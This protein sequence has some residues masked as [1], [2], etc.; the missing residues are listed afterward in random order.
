[1]DTNH[2]EL[3]GG[4]GF[5]EAEEEEENPVDKVIQQCINHLSRIAISASTFITS[6][7]FLEKIKKQL[8]ENTFGDVWAPQ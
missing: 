4:N 8:L 5:E 6:L 1:M 3:I 7:K 2:E